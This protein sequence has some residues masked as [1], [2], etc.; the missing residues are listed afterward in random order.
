MIANAASLRGNLPAMLGEKHGGSKWR[1]KLEIPIRTAKNC[2]L[3]PR[4]KERTIIKRF[5]LSNARKRA[6]A[7]YTE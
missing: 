1:A 2:L 6:A 7:T 4:L 3:R 5:G